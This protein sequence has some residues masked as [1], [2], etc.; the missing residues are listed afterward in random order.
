[1]ISEIFS[2]YLGIE[3]PT[4]TSFTDYKNHLRISSIC[5]LIVNL[6]NNFITFSGVIIN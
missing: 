3:E 1:M 6:L 5:R 4:N 2:T